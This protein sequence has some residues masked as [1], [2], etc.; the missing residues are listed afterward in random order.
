MCMSKLIASMAEPTS[1]MNF[2]RAQTI[3]EKAI[4]QKAVDKFVLD[5]STS[6]QSPP[7][8]GTCTGYP[9]VALPLQ[10]WSREPLQARGQSFVRDPAHA[11]WS[12]LPGSS[13]EGRSWGRAPPLIGSANVARDEL[14]GRTR[15]NDEKVLHG[16]T[17]SQAAASASA[18]ARVG[19]GQDVGDAQK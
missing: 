15:F 1:D 13:T 12:F 18:Q 9:A 6:K 14:E 7:K 3:G 10:L 4:E 8:F 5:P 16:H 17:M 2:P 11:A 19:R